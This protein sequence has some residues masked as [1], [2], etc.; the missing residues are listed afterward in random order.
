MPTP[1]KRSPAATPRRPSSPSARRAPRRPKPRE[2]SRAAG[3]S[4]TLLE[5]WPAWGALGLL[6]I[7]TAGT[8]ALNS[9]PECPDRSQAIPQEWADDVAR[10]AE[11]SGLPPELL[12]A[13]LDV[14]SRWDPEAES[15]V[16]AQ[17][18]AQ[19]MPETW[20]LYGE[21]EPTDPEASI[22]AQGYY[23]RDLRGMVAELDPADQQ[24]EI[25]L[26]LAAYN[27]GPT[28][29]LDAGGVP[30]YQETQ[31]YVEQITELSETRY[32]DVCEQ[33]A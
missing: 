27:A 20:E 26:V 22:R 23:L 33:E 29:V 15:P 11:V 7:G 32:A 8:I 19:F 9:D 17:G 31:G 5:A 4:S 3:R 2:G 18:L 21:G 24:E 12:A 6:A 13:Q 28:V 14:E 25:D 1:R 30:E 16:G 10:S